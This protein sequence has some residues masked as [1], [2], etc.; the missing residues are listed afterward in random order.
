MTLAVELFEPGVLIGIVGSVAV[1]LGIFFLGWA[2]KA[3][4]EAR[5]WKQAEAA[6]REGMGVLADRLKLA[7]EWNAELQG[8][9][10]ERDRIIKALEE[11]TA[12]QA[13]HIH[14]RDEQIQILLERTPEK[15]WEALTKH[16]AA[17]EVHTREAKSHWQIEREILS[18]IRDMRKEAN[19]GHG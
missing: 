4:S 16:T 11:R 14:H 12:A 15:L 19:G 7:N 1:P 3:T 18:E 9:Y 2:V 17:L 5:A 6:A 10:D 13:E 8:K